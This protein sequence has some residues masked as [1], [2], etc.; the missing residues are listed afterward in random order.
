MASMHGH[1]RS[2]LP[3]VHHPRGPRLGRIVIPS[4]ANWAL[5]ALRSLRAPATTKMS[6]RSPTAGG[7]M[8]LSRQTDGGVQIRTRWPRRAITVSPDPARGVERNERVR[9][10]AAVR[11]LW[12]PTGAPR[13]SRDCPTRRQSRTRLK[14]SMRRW[15]PRVERRKASLQRL[16]RSS[17]RDAPGFGRRVRIAVAGLRLTRRLTGVWAPVRP[18]AGQKPAAS[19]LRGPRCLHSALGRH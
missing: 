4:R 13:S 19:A 3:S 17:R 15:A 12:P 10:S 5:W 6:Q 11:Q 2:R 1:G 7:G 8:A 9:V 16:A 14:I 18:E